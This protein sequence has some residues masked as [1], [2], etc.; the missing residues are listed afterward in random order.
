MLN[1]ATNTWSQNALWSFLRIQTAANLLQFPMVFVRGL[2]SPSR[3]EGIGKVLRPSTAF[4]TDINGRDGRSNNA[5][6]AFCQRVAGLSADASS[7]ILFHIDFPGS[8]SY[9]GFDSFFHKDY[10]APEESRHDGFS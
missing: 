6:T 10:D 7:R 5:S 2:L 3:A 9:I 4:A 8:L 1:E